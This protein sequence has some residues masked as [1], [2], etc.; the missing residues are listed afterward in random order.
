M[1]VEMQS[2][3]PTIH[4]DADHEP[5][6]P[7]WED[8]NRELD[9]STLVAFVLHLWRFQSCGGGTGDAP[10]PA[11]GMALAYHGVRSMRHD[12]PRR[13]T[14]AAHQGKPDRWSC[15][16]CDTSGE[17]ADYAAYL[18]S[19]A[20]WAVLPPATQELIRKH[21]LGFVHGMT[22]GASR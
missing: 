9:L 18:C 14:I 12:A 11:C 8:L 3:T 13:V 10:C 16:R 21:C 7:C 1:E 5:T 15:A 19:G 4:R 20:P 22:N 17:T 2:L 6:L